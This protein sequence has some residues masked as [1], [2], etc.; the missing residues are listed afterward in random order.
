MC[1][2]KLGKATEHEWPF[3]YRLISRNF[4]QA[5]VDG[6]MTPKFSFRLYKD[7]AS[8]QGT[9]SVGKV[10]VILSCL[11]IIKH[12]PYEWRVHIAIKRC[13]LIKRI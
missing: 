9:A 7:G 12:K 4:L 2:R 3:I 6:G 8:L 11:N 5:L 1:D 10:Q 13:V